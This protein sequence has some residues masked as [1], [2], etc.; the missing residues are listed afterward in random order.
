MTK[1]KVP[2][3]ALKAV[4]STFCHA[5]LTTIAL[6]TTVGTGKPGSHEHFEPEEGTAAS[7]LGQTLSPPGTFHELQ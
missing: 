3:G 2:G 7:A 1:G 6:G 4:P 5:K